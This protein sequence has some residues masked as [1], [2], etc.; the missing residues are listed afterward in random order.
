MESSELLKLENWMSVEDYFLQI[1]L[2][3]YQHL[4]KEN[5]AYVNVLVLS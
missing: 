3:L 1:Q 2:Q 4:L 5:T